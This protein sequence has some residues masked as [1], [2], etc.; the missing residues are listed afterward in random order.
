MKKYLKK[1]QKNYK[2][3]IRKPTK[4]EYEKFINK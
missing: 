4:K 2:N 1:I 3:Q